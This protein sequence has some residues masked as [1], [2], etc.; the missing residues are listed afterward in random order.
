ML[1]IDKITYYKNNIFSNGNN[2][3]NMYSIFKNRLGIYIKL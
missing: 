3:N 1:Y 2:S